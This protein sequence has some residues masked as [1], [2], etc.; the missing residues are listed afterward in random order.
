M[1]R[2]KEKSTSNKMGSAPY[3][4]ATPPRMSRS[5][6]KGPGGDTFRVPSKA[7]YGLG[8]GQSPTRM[9]RSPS[10]GKSCGGF[11]LKA[12]GPATS[13]RKDTGSNKHAAK[14]YG[15]NGV[16]VKDNGGRYGV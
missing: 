15:V 7:K 1:E 16:S 2:K 11:D 9:D 6:G 8:E 13:S 4:D 3:Y 14:S 5:V 10:K 12:N